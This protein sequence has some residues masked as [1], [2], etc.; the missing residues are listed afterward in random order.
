MRYD[1]KRTTTGGSQ[2]LSC[3]LY[4][5]TMSTDTLQTFKLTCAMCMNLLI[6]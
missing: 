1:I 5:C 3:V 2:G 4:I 6:D